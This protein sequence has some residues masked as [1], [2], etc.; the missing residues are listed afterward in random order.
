M[1]VVPRKRSKTTT[2]YVTFQFQGRA[3]W[4]KSGTDLREAQRLDARRKRELKSGTY[5]PRKIRRLPTVAE[6]VDDWGPRRL[7][8][9]G[10]D[11]R[12]NLA[13]FTA[14]RDFAGMLLEDVR[15]RHVIDRLKALR[16]KVSEKTLRNAYG[17]LRTMYRDAVIDELVLANPCVLPRGFFQIDGQVEREAY[18]VAE[19][20]VL[21]SHHAIDWSTRVLNALC[22][23]AGLREGEA[24][25]RR[26]RDLDDCPKPLAALD[27]R[28]QYDG[29]PL[30]TKRP[31][32]V[33]VHPELERIL[34]E[35]AAVGFEELTCRKPTPDDFIVPRLV[36]RRVAGHTKSTY[37]KAFRQGCIAAG[38]RARSLHSTRHTMITLCR[39]GGADK[40]TLTKITHNPKGDIVDRYTHRDWQELCDVVLCLR[41]DA[42]LD[43]RRTLTS[44]R[45]SGP[46]NTRTGAPLL[47][48][49]VAPADYEPC[50][51]PGAG[52]KNRAEKGSHAKRRQ[53]S[54]QE[55][56]QAQGRTG[57][58][59]DFEIALA[60]HVERGSV[61]RLLGSPWP[62]PLP[63]AVRIALFRRAQVSAC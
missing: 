39:R 53:D 8:A 32:L 6:Y 48:S 42:R 3:V 25:G 46:E 12:R 55:A 37:Y 38:V 4:E 58:L 35:W 36:G 50:S 43:P 15:P 2:Y 9:A 13:R 20:A 28:D 59:D 29:Q 17:V 14:D 30:K 16:G 31:R 52:A 18:T 54:R 34:A 63:A 5:E 10:D 19:V 26:W 60:E 62:K 51:S 27:V 23:L 47:M 61:G 24:C 44:P 21:T 11:D 40:D 56:S 22:L 49:A 57:P 45:D 1:A 7:N 33:P 41:L